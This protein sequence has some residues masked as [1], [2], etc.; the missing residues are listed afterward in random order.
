[1]W[2]AIF[3]GV[4]GIGSAAVLYLWPQ[5][6]PSNPIMFWVV[7]FGFPAGV[8]AV[9]F[10]VVFDRRQQAQLQYN[11]RK[12]E[13]ARLRGLWRNW[14]NRGIGVVRATTFLAGIE[15]TEG[16]ESMD[17]VLP[18]NIGR[19]Q[20]LDWLP[21]EKEGE[22][23]QTL[24]D[25]VTDRFAGEMV[26]LRALEVLL[27][28]DEVSLVQ[29]EQWES[30]ARKTFSCGGRRVSVSTL[31]ASAGL[32]NLE[33]RL[34]QDT[35]PAQ[36]LIAF[37]LRH[38]A[39]EAPYSEG[40]A[41]IL[42]RP[43]VK[44]DPIREPEIV[45]GGADILRPMISSAA[46]LQV[47]FKQMQ[48]WQGAGNH[49]E[50]LWSAGLNE[51]AQADMGG[52]LPMKCES[53]RDMDRCLGLAGPATSWITLALALDIGMRTGKRQFVAATETGTRT[54]RCIVSPLVKEV[55]N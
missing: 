37:Q 40:G 44:P 13:N 20:K 41:A 52:R 26:G 46:E 50:H 2:L 8:F 51:A 15:G 21:A 27:L 22:R 43:I 6:R 47:D 35:G 32:A 4:L 16:W 10:G 24:L 25:L 11:E 23:M 31:P 30:A 54:V 3:F 12:R 33:S 17:A 5:G 19:A 7:L 29:R 1:M 18:V 45:I 42:L 38:G 53:Y 39:I 9:I 28:L 49:T 36:L 34:T 14:A 55:S 48:E